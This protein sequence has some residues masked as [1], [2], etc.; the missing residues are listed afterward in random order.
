MKY[1]ASIFVAL[2]LSACETVT[3]EDGSQVTRFD[4]ATANQLIQT[5]FDTYDR[6]Q[7]YRRPAPVVV[8]P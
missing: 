7:G 1:I 4:A 6:Y 8:V 5:G 3:N 2:V